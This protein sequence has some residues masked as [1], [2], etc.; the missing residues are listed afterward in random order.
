MIAPLRAYILSRL[1]TLTKLD[2]VYDYH[3]DGADGYP[4]A[5]FEPSRVVAEEYDSC[6]NKMTYDF[7]I[8]V[9]VKILEDLIDRES[10]TDILVWVVDDMTNLFNQDQSLG[11]LATR[12]IIRDIQFWV[13]LHDKWEVSYVA[14]T[15]SV[16]NLSPIF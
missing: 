3:I 15:L 1:Q 2:K 6:N 11:G 10:A 14:C 5:T 13:V 12:S 4:C 9:Q 16:D 7:D 8:I